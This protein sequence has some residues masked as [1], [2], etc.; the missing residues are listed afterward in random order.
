MNDMESF[1][2]ALAAWGAASGNEAGRQVPLFLQ[3]AA[4]AGRLRFQRTGEL[5]PP[6]G[7]EVL[8]SGVPAAFV[9]AAVFAV[10]AALIAVAAVQVS[11]SH[12]QRLQGG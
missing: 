4:P 5:P 7:A 11:P 12:L 6:W 1:R 9:M 2:C 10:P 3:Q 8:A